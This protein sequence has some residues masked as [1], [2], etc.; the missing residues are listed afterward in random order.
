MMASPKPP[1]ITFKDI[2]D[3]L[4]AAKRE[5][6][7]VVHP[8]NLEFAQQAIKEMDLGP[9][10]KVYVVTNKYINVDQAYIMDRQS[11]NYAY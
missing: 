6:S 9:W 2:Q 5:Y 1:P 7:L 8:D 10:T 11:L 3:T 4:E